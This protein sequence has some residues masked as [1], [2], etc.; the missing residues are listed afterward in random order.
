MRLFAE[1]KIGIAALAI[2][3]LSAAPV[4][5]QDDDWGDSWDEPAPA[6]ADVPTSKTETPPLVTPS[7]F[8]LNEDPGVNSMDTQLEGLGMDVT[9][10][11]FKIDYKIPFN[12]VVVVKVYGPDSVL[13]W[14]EQYPMLR[15]EHTIR[16]RSRG[17]LARGIYRYELFYKGKAYRNTFDY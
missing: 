7:N 8:I 6:D 9:P 4:W 17:G 16:A 13:V 1:F 2:C 12:G 5:A 15:G 14:R 3:L 11:G 10:S